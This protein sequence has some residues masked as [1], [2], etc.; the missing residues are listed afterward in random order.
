MNTDTPTPAGALLDVAVL[1]LMNTPGLQEEL[2]PAFL[3]HRPNAAEWPPAVL[4]ALRFRTECR[5]GR[6]DLGEGTVFLLNERGGGTL[7]PLGPNCLCRVSIY[8]ELPRS[9]A[10]GE[11][12]YDNEP[13][14]DVAFD[15]E[16]ARRIPSLGLLR[17]EE[18]LL[19]RLEGVEQAYLEWRRLLESEMS[20][21]LAKRKPRSYTVEEA[22]VHV[23]QEP[24]Y[25]LAQAAR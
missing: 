22:P 1:D 8:A 13:F 24:P 16:Q 7:A 4:Q 19:R 17:L 9:A 3:R 10:T 6:V 23:V 5:W 2:L 21:L 18:F 12:F 11:G 25:P 14:I 15:A 20:R